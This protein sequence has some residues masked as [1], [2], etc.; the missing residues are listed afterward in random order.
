[1]LVVGNDNCK[2]TGTRINGGKRRGCSIRCEGNR[3]VREV[4]KLISFLNPGIALI[5]LHT[6]CFAAAVLSMS[7]KTTKS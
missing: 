6:T 7:R 1:M 5:L 4:K 3:A 2:E